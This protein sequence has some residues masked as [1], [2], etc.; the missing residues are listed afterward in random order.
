VRILALTDF[1]PPVIG[2]LE[3]NVSG[4]SRELA[5]R[6]HHVAVATL[7]RPGSSP[8]EMD[9]GVR[10]HR[11]DG[12]SRALRRTYADPDRPFH[13]TLADPG[14]SAALRRVVAAERPQIVQAHSWI[15][16]SFLPLK[17]WSGAK[18]V[19]YLHDYGLRCAKKTFLRNGGPCDGPAY[20]KCVSCAS[21]HYGA[22]KG[23]AL[24]S[25]L[26]L[27]SRMYGRVDRFLANSSA[28]ADAGFDGPGPRPA[29]IDV[30]PSFVPDR[31]AELGSAL[32]RP[33]FLP[34]QDG[35]VLFVGA[36]GDHKGLG[37]LLEACQGL[38]APLVVIGTRRADTPERFPTG[39]TVVEDVPHDE[40]M[41]AWARS[42]VAVVPSKWPE[43]FGQVAVE[44]MMSGKPV[45]ASSVGGLCDVV[46]D[47][48]T[49]VLVPPGDA[50][51][52]RRAVA[53]L[54][55]DPDR[56]TRMGEAGRRR[57]ARFTL[58]RVADRMEDVYRELLDEDGRS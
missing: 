45:V 29:R 15:L 53:E 51:A 21:D 58:S 33:A 39:V 23:A 41:A 25:G 6:G 52:L 35:Y 32:P 38:D 20:G 11:I 48:E 44:A 24:T 56:R 28:V 19:V 17:P 10:V 5:R 55:A 31:A 57:A 3:R 37:V 26:W 36:L 9:E 47:G 34:P 16:H 13:P 12:W 42:S 2:G 1:Y 49:G 7:S 22:V 8:V 40:V 18:L 54:L 43:P 14:V 50:G 46:V 4:I 27:S 30:V